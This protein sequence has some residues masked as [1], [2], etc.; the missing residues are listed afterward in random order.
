MKKVYISP[1]VKSI[2]LE[3]DC[4]IA[5]S[6]LDGKSVNINSENHDAD[7]DA[8]SREEGDQIWSKTWW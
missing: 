8:M 5:L 4:L 2:D 7:T 3:L 1:K 6:S